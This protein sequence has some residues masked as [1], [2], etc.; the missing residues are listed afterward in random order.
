[1]LK[2]NIPSKVKEYKE[3]TALPTADAVSRAGAEVAALKQQAAEAAAKLQSREHEIASAEHELGSLRKKIE[4]VANQLGQVRN[5]QSGFDTASLKAA[6]KRHFIQSVI[7]DD[8]SEHHRQRQEYT[9]L[10]PAILGHDLCVEALAESEAVLDA[11][12]KRLTE[13]QEQL[14]AVLA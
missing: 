11:D 13:R 5:A 10:A 1:M 4:V 2:T 12:M 3:E 8:I 6:F 7:T 9:A 14:Q